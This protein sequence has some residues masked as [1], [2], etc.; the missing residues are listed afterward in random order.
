MTLAKV[1]RVLVGAA[2]LSTAVATFPAVHAYR[3]MDADLVEA[4]ALV[5]DACGDNSAWGQALCQNAKGI[6]TVLER[7]HA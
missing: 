7:R 5:K 4:M 1:K 2:L 6:L 3:P